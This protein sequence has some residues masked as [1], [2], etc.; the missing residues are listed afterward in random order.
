MKLK[1][2]VNLK[3]S[4]TIPMMTVAKLHLVCDIEITFRLLE[5]SLI[6]F[7]VEFERSY[8]YQQIKTVLCPVVDDAGATCCVLYYCTVDD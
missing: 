4:C 7:T 2:F 1:R 6:H 5:L 8:R 3:K